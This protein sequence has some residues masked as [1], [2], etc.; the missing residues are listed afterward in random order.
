MCGYVWFMCGYGYMALCAK[1]SEANAGLL[2][3]QKSKRNWPPKKNK[4]KLC[5]NS[6]ALL[7]HI[8][9]GITG[10]ADNSFFLKLMQQTCINMFKVLLLSLLL[11]LRKGY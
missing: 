4:L 2:E 9:T 1:L 8:K 3:K 6:R 11:R 10:P 5:G 7:I